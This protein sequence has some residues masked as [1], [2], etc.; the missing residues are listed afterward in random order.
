MKCRFKLGLKQLSSL[1]NRRSTIHTDGRHCITQPTSAWRWRALLP[2]TVRSSRPSPQET[3]WWGGYPNTICALFHHH[4]PLHFVFS[5]E[6]A[7]L[8]FLDQQRC[9]ACKQ[10]ATEFIVER[11]RQPISN[12][13][14]FEQ[15]FRL[16]YISRNSLQ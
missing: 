12:A 10:D 11:L 3:W 2:Y 9:S 7:L 1:S 6:S 4:N 8:Y 14:V 5:G 13:V 15:G 16:V